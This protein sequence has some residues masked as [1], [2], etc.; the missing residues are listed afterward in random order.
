MTIAE[1]GRHSGVGVETVRYYQRLG[2][3]TVPEQHNHGHRRYGQES[4]AELSFVRRCKGLGFSLKQVGEL[5]HLRRGHR[6]ACGKLH[7]HLVELRAHLA[8]KQRELETQQRAVTS[9]LASC[10]GARAIG[11]CAA[12]AQLTV[13]DCPPPEAS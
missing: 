1:L 13:L 12:L 5:V 10:N 6:A 11:E 2:L 3:L 7:D 8:A 9:L 4:L